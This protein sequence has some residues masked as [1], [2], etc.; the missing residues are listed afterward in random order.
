MWGLPRPGAKPMSPELTGRFFITE[1]PRKPSIIFFHLALQS[2]IDG[3]Q[4]ALNISIPLEIYSSTVPPKNVGPIYTI[5]SNRLTHCIRSASALGDFCFLR[6]FFFFVI[7]NFIAMPWCL[8]IN[9]N[10]HFSHN[11]VSLSFLTVTLTWLTCSGEM[12]R[13]STGREPVSGHL[14][15]N[16]QLTHVKM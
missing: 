12:S 1:V 10:F 9:F 2:R 14:E 7:W 15:E 16:K 6:F 4:Q 13:V 8:V 5:T 3:G 11:Y